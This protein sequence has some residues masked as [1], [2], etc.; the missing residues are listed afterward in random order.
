MLG[1][2]RSNRTLPVTTPL[3]VFEYLNSD[4]VA[5]AQ[6][7]RAYD[8][9]AVLDEIPGFIRLRLNEF[10]VLIERRH[11]LVGNVDR[12]ITLLQQL[13]QDDRSIRPAVHAHQMQRG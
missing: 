1:D 7:A 3:L 6:V 9:V 11:F 5:L 13:P 12:G 10:Y 8:P 4:L 2:N